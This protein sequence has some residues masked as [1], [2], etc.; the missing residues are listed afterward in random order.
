M[1]GIISSFDDLYASE[2]IPADASGSLAVIA[3]FLDSMHP[4][5][6]LIAD[7]NGAVIAAEAPGGTLDSEAESLA[8]AL[9]THLAADGGLDRPAFGAG[10]AW[11]AFGIRL[12]R[13]ADRA[14]FGGLFQ[15]GSECR[16]RLAEVL[17][18]LTLSGTLA[19]HRV[20]SFEAEQTLHTRVRH[21]LAERDTLKTSHT[22]LVAKAIEE[23]QQRVYER[24]HRLALEK[25]YEAAET[26]NQAK[27][28]FLANMSHEL[29]TPLHT[30][31]SFATFGLKKAVS[32]ERKDLLQYFEK[33]DRGGK[34]LLALINDLLDIAKLESGRA[35]YDPVQF[36]LRAIA[37]CVADEFSSMA[38]HRGISIRLQPTGFAPIVLADQAKMMQVLRNL[39]SNA[40]KFSP[41]GSV[42]EI[43]LSRVGMAVQ[44]A[45][46]DQGIGIPEDELE[47]I[48]DKFIQSS[49]TRTGAGGTGLGLAICREILS[50]HQGRIWAE[51]RAEGG[52]VVRFEIPLAPANLT[53]PE[54]SRS[55]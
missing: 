21:L 14:I 18:A 33:I 1:E 50:G 9:G 41:D 45:V 44:V 3:R 30:I 35:R 52:A 49:K 17:P 39:L 47:T 7:R 28:E 16:K 10:R 27:T 25:L 26:A 6:L 19:W 37:H 53:Q 24:E 13:D 34:T 54:V 4:H 23:H 38:D 22:E 40:I 5:L 20:R 15:E 31:L 12:S 51:N 55:L 36:D 29:R 46:C 32:G 11:L 42:I 48:F 43:E 8:P 2:G